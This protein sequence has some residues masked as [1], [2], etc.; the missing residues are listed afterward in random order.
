MVV[1]ADFQ[2]LGLDH[3]GVWLVMIDGNCRLGSLPSP[4]VGTKDRD[5]EDSS[6]SWF[7]ELLRRLR[8]FAP[9][10]YD[11]FFSGPSGTMFQKRNASFG[12]GDFLGIPLSWTGHSVWACTDH[13]ISAGHQVMDHR[14]VVGYVKILFESGGRT[15]QVRRNGIDQKALADP[16]KRH[17]GQ[18]VIDTIPEVPWD[19]SVHQHCEVITGHLQQGSAIHYPVVKGRLRADYFTDVTSQLHRTLCQALGWTRVRCAFLQRA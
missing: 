12:R 10:T 14:S 4:H 18:H 19:V 7:H 6:G 17:L 5:E 13:A 9:S 3:G 8:L 16:C 15:T 11:G 1:P 2:M